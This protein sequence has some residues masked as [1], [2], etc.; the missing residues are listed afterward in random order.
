MKGLILLI[1]W[2][3]L[4][5]TSFGQNSFVI[6][7]ES[8]K[9]FDN[10][11]FETKIEG[12]DTIFVEAKRK[13][14]ITLHNF[15][16]NEDSPIVVINKNGIVNI[17]DTVA[18][19]AFELRECSHVR[20]VGVGDS[21]SQCGFILCSKN[22][23]VSVTELSSHIEISH[24]KID[25]NGFFGIVVK[26][27]YHGNP[28]NPVPVFEKLNIHDCEIYNVT[29]GM[30]L[31]ETKTP[32]M[33]F[34][35]VRIYNNIVSNTGREAIQIANMV[36]DVEVF[37]NIL[38]NSGQDETDWQGSNFQVGDNSVGHF[39]HNIFLNGHS[40]GAIVLGAGD[41]TMSENY[42]GNNQGV[43]IDNRTVTIP[44]S[45][46]DI[47]AN[48]FRDMNDD[49]VIKIINEKN[50]IN[51]FDNVWYST[52]S[53]NF[54]EVLNS[55][56]QITETNNLYNLFAP[57]LVENYKIISLNPAEYLKLGPQEGLTHQFNYKPIIEEIQNCVF[58][59]NTK[60]IIEIKASTPDF[61]NVSFILVDTL[62]FV[63]FTDL[64]N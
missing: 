9:Y 58:K 42:F 62:D 21:T 41:I 5:A 38:M 60:N 18:A 7:E 34:K 11:N 20:L 23:G 33:E 40:Y 63:F 36:E 43:F 17:N 64:E 19:G 12:G 57:I 50:H 31:G 14:A 8:P 32:G 15:H 13:D 27:D 56:V 51:L 39:H 16:G 24:V 1:F 46:I 61:D 25:H 26:K 49:V 22:S 3:T 29:E 35:H 55:G 52:K 54:T 44:Y 2:M 48:Y 59:P 47:T 10:N 28:P 37:N 6:T 53:F 4:Y 45:S 30:Y